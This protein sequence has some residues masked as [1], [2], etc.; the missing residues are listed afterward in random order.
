MKT[1][2]K[3]WRSKTKIFLLFIIIGKSTSGKRAN[4]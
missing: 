2:Q 1:N 4:S 3:F